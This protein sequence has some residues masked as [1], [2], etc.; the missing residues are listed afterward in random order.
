MKKGSKILLTILVF[1]V[2]LAILSSPARYVESAKGGMTLLAGAVLPS[3]LPFFFLTALLSAIGVTDT[4]II[5]RILKKLYGSPRIGGYV[6]LMSIISGYPMSAKLLGELYVR[7]EISRE[8]AEN[9][10]AYS[11]VSGPMFIIG[12]VGAVLLRNVKSGVIIFVSHL[13]GSLLNG[14]IYRS[15]KGG[16][17]SPPRA[18]FSTSPPSN[19][20]STC[21]ES[22]AR[23]ALT[24][25]VFVILFS[26]ACT[27]AKTSGLP[28]LIASLG[29]FMGINK[30]LTYGVIYCI[31]EITCGID[32]LKN[33]TSPILLPL[34]SASISF[35]GISIA[36]QSLSFLAGAVSAK[37]YFL[38]KTTQSLLSFVVCAVIILI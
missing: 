11:S 19:I 1:T 28:A 34:I 36:L 16:K 7:G 14:F 10:S 23:S 33:F 21:A 25:S 20:I 13:V 9:V 30:N 38:M 37:K 29:D 35:G 24:V 32:Y 6:F 22:T 3:L 5:S 17:S 8:E 26:V 18:V 4:G 27:L 15:K 2:M 31:L 12:T